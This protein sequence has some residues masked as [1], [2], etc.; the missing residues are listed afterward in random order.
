MFAHQVKQRPKVVG[1]QRLRT[2]NTT[3]TPTYSALVIAPSKPPATSFTLDALQRGYCG[4]SRL[5]CQNVKWGADFVV[6]RNH[7][8]ARP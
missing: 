6:P 3:N 4:G 2:T 7:S 8:Q 5:G 1:G